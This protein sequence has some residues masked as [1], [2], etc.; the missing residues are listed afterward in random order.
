MNLEEKG[1]EGKAV[2]T[3]PKRRVGGFVWGKGG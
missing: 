2:D 1:A 3:T